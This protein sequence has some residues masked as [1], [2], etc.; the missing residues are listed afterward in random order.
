MR[1]LLLPF[2]DALF[3]V[4]FSFECEGEE[5]LPA[6]GPAVVA[7]NHPSYL[8]PLLLSVRA[9]RPIR[10]MAWDALF[11][12]PVLG[13]AMRAFGAFPVDVRPGHGREAFARA[14][15]LIEAGEVVGL[16]PEGKRSRTGW[17]EPALREGAAR[18]AWETGAPL[19]PATIA[20]AF[21]AWPYHQTLPR[22][23]RIKVRFH[24]AI[25]PG[26]WRGKPEDEAL[27]GLLAELRRRV[28]RT[29][30]PGVKADLRMNLVYRRPSPWPRWHE[31]LPALVAA[32]LVFWQTR[33]LLAVAPAYGYI[34]YLLLD[35][36][37]VPQGRLVKWLRNSSPVALGLGYAPVVAGSLGLPD[38]P[39]DVA[40]A[41]IVAGALFPYLYERGNTALAFVRGFMLALGLELGAL[42]LAPIDVGPHVALPLY[43]AAFAWQKR[44]VYST[45]AAPVLALWAM[46]VPR[47]L[48]G[49]SLSLV[50]HGVAGLLAWLVASM[51]PYRSEAPREE[52]VGPTGL[53]LQ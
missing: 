3:R 39:G 40:L 15:E 30:L 17:M 13:A 5:N 23:G 49:L 4:W 45:Y 41:A 32:V 51:V 6:Q 26:P 43:A 14:K 44:T 9:K 31:F 36:F 18:L 10:F 7:A 42:W 27:A 11:K 47:E 33:S 37:L 46:L 2:V 35:H 24:E 53:G 12:V 25:D 48:A 22:P 34:A 21:R 28:E 20:G 19:V 29:L 38:T 50:P 8:D 52:P 1:R 16:F